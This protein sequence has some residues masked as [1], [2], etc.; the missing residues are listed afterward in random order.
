MNLTDEHDEFLLN[1]FL[2]GDLPD[3]EVAALNDRL[4]REPGLRATL[5]A[6]TRIDALL[7]DRRSQEPG[8]DWSRFRADVMDQVT[9]RA[10]S[11]VRI[12]RLP[13][14]VR[15]AAPL[16]VAASL[17]L[18]ITLRQWPRALKDSSAHPVRVAYHTP[19][20]EAAGQLVV[21]YNRHPT[22][23]DRD[24]AAHKPSRVA[25]TR[26][27]EL[28]EAIRKYDKARENRPSWHLYAAH[29]E[30][31]QPA[32]DDFFDISAMSK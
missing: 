16:A 18:V 23:S 5:D 15:V 2:D 17:A 3:D 32:I 25:Y 29:A 6:L 1:R 20:P 30:V 27:D 19:A 26:S 8:V 12:V 28:K 21:E 11:P 9:A 13:R 4:A 14:W 24:R 7:A 22:P 31:P 10:A